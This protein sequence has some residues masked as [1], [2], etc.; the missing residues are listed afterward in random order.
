MVLLLALLHL[1]G[2]EKIEWSEAHGVALALPPN[3]VIETR[4]EKTTV[5]RIRSPKVGGAY[6]IASLLF[7]GPAGAPLPEMA[8]RVGAELGKRPLWRVTGENPG[9]VGPF[10]CIR[11]GA[12]FEKDRRPGQARVSV[13]LLS[14]RY[15]LLELA[16]PGAHF[17]ASTYERLEESIEVRW[18]EAKHPSG[19]L[20][21][22]PPGWSVASAEADAWGLRGPVEGL[23]VL[24]RRAPKEPPPPSGLELTLLGE[25]LKG[26]IEDRKGVRMVRVSGGDWSAAIAMPEGLWDDHYPL[27]AAVVA[28]VRMAR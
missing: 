25:R 12:A 1:A 11:I 17:P 13:L 5:F 16:S 6:A 15:F 28:R 14:D 21:S 3:W 9:S 24:L 20:A 8:K 19:L 27:A 22:L 7:A 26:R 10:R 2:G 4:D 23:L 18:S